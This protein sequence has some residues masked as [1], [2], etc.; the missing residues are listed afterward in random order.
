MVALAWPVDRQRGCGRADR[1]QGMGWM[2]DPRDRP[3][4]VCS[5]F[6][7]KTTAPWGWILAYCRTCRRM[8][9]VE[10]GRPPQGTNVATL[11]LEHT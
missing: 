2:T 3:C 6:C 4:P 10:L 1:S 11:T 8:R 7:V 5:H 9:K